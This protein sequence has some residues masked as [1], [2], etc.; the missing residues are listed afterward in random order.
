MCARLR[1]L[2]RARV[3][4]IVMSAFF[5]L[6]FAQAEGTKR[7]LVLHTDS[8][9][10]PGNAIVSKAI[11]ETI[12]REQGNQIFEE[13]MDENRL[14]PNYPLIVDTLR[15]KYAGQKI[16][17][18]I[19]FGPQPF[20][21]FLHYGQDLWPTTPIIFSAVEARELPQKL[22]LNMTGVVGSFDFSSN[23]DLALAL[24]PELRHV[25]YIGG[26]TPQEIGRR[27]TAEEDFKHYGRKLEFTYLNDLPF[28]ELLNRVSDLPE[29]SIVL[30][31]TFFKDASGE[32]YIPVRA[33]PLIV[34][35]SNAPVYGVFET[36]LGC[37]IVG[38]AIFNVDA[39]VRQAANMGLRILHGE[40]IAHLP[41]EQGPP[42][43][44]IVDWRQ[45]QKWGIPES[46]LPPGTTV[47]YRAPSVWALYK[48]YL[49]LGIAVLVIQSCLI[50]L[51]IVQMRRC[52]RSDIAIRHLTRR[53][54]KA[55]EDERRYI[56]REL[57]DDLGQRLSLIAIQLAQDSKNN[58]GNTNESLHELDTVISDVHNL[59]HS[60]HSTKLEH[61]GL[62]AAIG[63]LCRKLSQRYDLEIVLQ[64]NE[65]P[66]DL[67]P[68]V[69]LCFYRV[70]QEALNNAIKH[71]SASHVLLALTWEN[72]HLT[73]SVRDDGV[74]FNPASA[75][76]GLGLATMEERLLTVGG[77]LTIVSK[78][79]AGTTITAQV[80]MPT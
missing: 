21:M 25:F 77:V 45:L 41:V 24:Q 57:H 6:H 33:C 15:E 18:V 8:S 53:L 29:R 34:D 36:Y 65:V 11:Q 75:Q 66:V 31:T 69:A 16:D 56:A 22:P 73:M 20:G 42:N 12:G 47:M 52:K 1:L 54:I 64:P 32:P 3:L 68:D 79:S 26:A 61:L 40:S 67:S 19:T 74:G 9:R 62:N 2:T 5:P 23:V 4:L 17:L 60:L 38:G 51:L 63:E 10:L 55:G 72:G 78:P 43:K 59:S 14:G 30:Y 35:S 44:F 39:N 46:R 7:I 71:S 37:G 48:K 13:Y 28:P 70:A 80:P 76:R 27:A 49:L 50:V 58:E